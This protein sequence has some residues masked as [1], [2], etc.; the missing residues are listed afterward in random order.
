[1]CCKETEVNVILDD[2]DVQT[3]TDR[4]AIAAE[5]YS[6]NII[7]NVQCD[8]PFLPEELI[9]NVI[10][11]LE[12]ADTNYINSCYTII[13]EKDAMNPNNVKVVL[14]KD[15]FALYFSRALIPFHRENVENKCYYKHI[16]IYGFHRDVLMNFRS[17]EEGLLEKVEKLEQLRALENNIKIKMLEWHSD[18]VSINTYEDVVLAE[19]SL[20]GN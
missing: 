17:L 3:G 12:N 20:K 6:D 13:S 16:G 8:E 1:V 4:V 9:N 5:K 7:V 10:S 2:T 11:D 15:N 14:D 18:I 19:N